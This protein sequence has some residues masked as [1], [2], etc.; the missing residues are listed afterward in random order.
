MPFVIVDSSGVHAQSLEDAL[1]ETRQEFAD[2]FGED[3]AN[4]DQTPQGQLAGVFAMA[5]A[6]IGEALVDL[7][8]AFDPNNSIGTQLDRLYGL[9]DLIRQTATR[10]RVTATVTGIAGTGLPSGSRAKTM[11]GAEFRTLAAAVLAPSPGIMVEMEAVDAGAVVADAG[12]LTEIVTVVPGWETI[13]NAEAAVPGMVRQNDPGYRAAY[14]ARTAHRSVG[15]LSALE[16]ALSSG[17]GNQA[18]GL[19]KR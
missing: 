9:L 15:S 2:I 5:K 18:Q 12:T 14:S 3:L 11:A 13:T 7:G 8:T 6:I 16:S 1:N 19:R 10:S 17:N 4:A